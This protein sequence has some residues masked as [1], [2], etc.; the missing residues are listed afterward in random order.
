MARVSSASRSWSMV[1]RSTAAAMAKQAS[2]VS[3]VV[4]ALV[5]A[6]PI[7]GPALVGRTRSDSRAI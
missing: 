7:S 1:P 3:W 5:E 2:V 4:K 6:T